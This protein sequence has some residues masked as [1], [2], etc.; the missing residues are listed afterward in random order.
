M[1]RGKIGIS[2]LSHTWRG[3]FP[4]TAIQEPL[5]EEGTIFPSLS[6]AS[7]RSLPSPD[8]QAICPPG[9]RPKAQGLRFC[10]KGQQKPSVQVSRPQRLCSAANELGHSMALTCSLVPE[11]GAVPP[12]PDALR[13]G[14]LS[15][16]ATQG[17]LRP[18]HSQASALLLHRSAQHP[19][20]CGK[21]LSL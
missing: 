13:K 16:R 2:L 6:Q 11:T 19:W 15:L 18:V 12:L 3:E 7:L 10:G 1:G 17:I 14:E 21:L 4:H 9:S 8:V 20:P 5:T